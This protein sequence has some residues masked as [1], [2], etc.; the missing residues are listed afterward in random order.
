MD[1]TRNETPAAAVENPPE[2]VKAEGQSSEE[3]A[4]A[5]A[6][7]KAKAESVAKAEAAEQNRLKDELHQRLKAEAEAE[8]AKAEIPG[9]PADA[10]PAD[11]MLDVL[12]RLRKLEEWKEQTEVQLARRGIG[13]QKWRD[14][15]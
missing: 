13:S 2:P 12:I 5:E 14:K 1:D 7:A 11:M 10:T 6:A 9:L 4:A 8:Q 15:R 3:I